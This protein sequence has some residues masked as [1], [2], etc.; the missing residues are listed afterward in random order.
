MSIEK[1]FTL[2]QFRTQVIVHIVII[3]VIL[4]LEIYLIFNGQ[5]YLTLTFLAALLFYFIYKLFALVNKTNR[6]LTNF[7]MSIRFDDYE[8]TYSQKNDGSEGDKTSL[9]NAFNLITGKFRDIRSEKEA[10][11]QFLLA[12]VEQVDT[13]LI[14]FDDQGRTIK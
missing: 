2:D 8:T 1:D 13:G 10:Q 3:T 14:C 6:D 5:S 4:T 11:H 9:Y 12:L 7:L